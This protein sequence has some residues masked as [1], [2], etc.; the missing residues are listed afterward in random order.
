M[1]PLLI[2][3]RLFDLYQALIRSR[4]QVRTAIEAWRLSCRGSEWVLEKFS[5]HRWQVILVFS[6]WLLWLFSECVYVILYQ[7]GTAGTKHNSP[8]GYINELP[9]QVLNSKPKFSIENLQISPAKHVFFPILHSRPSSYLAL[10]AHHKSC[11]GRGQ[12]RLQCLGKMPGVVWGS[13]ATK[14]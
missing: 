2:G 9:A 10:A 6:G 8:R 11:A 12:G 14:I 5:S 7:L 13:P 1:Q 4:W 3:V